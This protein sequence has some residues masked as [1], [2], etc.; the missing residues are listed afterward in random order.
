MKQ[1]TITLAVISALALRT[2]IAAE[3]KWEGQVTEMG[4][5]IMQ[6]SAINAINGLNLSRDQAVKLRA[7]AK[8]VE[9]AGARQPKVD[10]PFC[11][12]LEGVRK[13]YHELRDLLVQGR[14]VPKDLHGRVAK[15]RIAEA[16]VLRES[17][18]TAPL[19][20]ERYGRCT[21]CHP[22]PR[23]SP[24]RK[25]AQG[26][27]ADT[28]L[29]DIRHGDKRRIFMAHAL[30]LYGVRGLQRVALSAPKVDTL[31]SA[32]QRE[33]MQKFACCLL[34]PEGLSDPVRAGQAEVSEG[35][36]KVIRAAH[37]TKPNAWS[38]VRAVIINQM[39][40]GQQAKTPGMSER[41]RRKVQ[42]H[43]IGV[44]EKARKLS[45]V[46]FELEKE[47]LCR[48]LKTGGAPSEDKPGHVR[49]FMAAYFLL[50]PGLDEMY[51]EVTRRHDD[52]SHGQQARSLSRCPT[53]DSK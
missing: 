48:D 26:R 47:N 31:L 16:A 10:A 8:Q 46:E 4:Y 49:R 35:A 13:T 32:G 23:T 43:L 36:M 19:P 22:A 17:M 27:A 15:A 5:L 50:L 7:M 30:G 3:A 2:L 29:H 21:S 1:R 18:A 25:P 28:R 52:P 6:L 39:L 37:D 41:D 24:K 45:D 20:S 12:K 42:E 11:P 9:A 51:T 38:Y 53:W 14:P 34:P 40:K 33:I 44:L